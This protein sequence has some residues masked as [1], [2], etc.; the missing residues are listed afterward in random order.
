M[1]GWL[2]VPLVEKLN[3]SS[4]KLQRGQAWGESEDCT[5]QVV[6]VCK[7][8][9]SRGGEGQW[10]FRP[11]GEGEGSRCP[12]QVV[13]VD[14]TSQNLRVKRESRLQLGEEEHS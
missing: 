10:A 3:K 11:L 4:Y 14:L 13:A 6:G 8:H 5:H 7:G 12:Y 1:V 2:N 9:H